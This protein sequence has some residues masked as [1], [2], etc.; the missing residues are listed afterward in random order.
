[1]RFLCGRARAST[2]GLAGRVGAAAKTAHLVD[3]LFD[4]FLTTAPP[5]GRIDRLDARGGRATDFKPASTLHHIIG[6]VDVVVS[7]VNH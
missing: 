3:A 7:S 1:M 6:A 2:V 4:R 5:G